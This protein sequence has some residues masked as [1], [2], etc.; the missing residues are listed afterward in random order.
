MGG[1]GCDD[2]EG[3]TMAEPTK[4]KTEA[5][6]RPKGTEARRCGTCDMF[7]APAACTLVK[8]EIAADAICAFWEP[9]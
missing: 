3:L 5:G 2:A 8:G 7:V 6:Y 4:T 1:K 9:K